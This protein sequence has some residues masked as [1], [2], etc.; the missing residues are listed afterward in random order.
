MIITWDPAK[1]RRNKHLHGIDFATAQY[2]FNDPNQV[3]FYDEN[4]STPA[5]DRYNVIGFV[6]SL[7]FVVYTERTTLAG[8][9]VIR[10]ISARRAT[11]QEEEVYVCS[12]Q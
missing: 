10:I 7:L 2:V 5:E 3:E 4:H 6:D 8:Q 9:E 12:L 11:S 1:N